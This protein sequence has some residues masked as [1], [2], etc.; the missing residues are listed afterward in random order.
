[1]THSHTV[2]DSNSVRFTRPAFLAPRTLTA[3]ALLPALLLALLLSGTRA[4]AATIYVDNLLGRD[5]CRGTVSEPIDRISGPVRT[6]DRA[7]ALAGPSDTIHLANTGRPYAG[8]LRLFGRRHSGI[9]TLPFRVL[10]N[11]AVISGAKPVPSA[12]WRSV[13][14]LW[15]LAPRRKG[16]FLLLRDGKPLPRHTFPPNGAAP[17]HE[18]IPDGHWGVWNGKIYYRTIELLDT[19][20]AGLAIATGDCGIT[21]FAV[22][23]VQIENLVVQHWRLDGISAPGLCSDVVLKNVVCRENGRAGLVLSGT[24]QVRAETLQL[25]GNLEHSMLIE[26]YGL[27]DIVDGKFSKPP[28]LSP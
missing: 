8:D 22:R 3:V 19:G 12:A 23:H 2:S 11:G 15:Q 9:A 17:K 4:A 10:G 13:G 24:S 20:V 6:L 14:G 16:R 21:L 18:T 28:T 27:A 26:D 1:M 7:V 25:T 5:I